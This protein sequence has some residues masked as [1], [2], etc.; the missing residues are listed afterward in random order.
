[1]CRLLSP[2]FQ[3]GVKKLFD[4]HFD[5]YEG[6]LLGACVVFLLIFIPS[7]PTLLRII[8]NLLTSPRSRL[9]RLESE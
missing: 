1:M 8:Y 4:D 3:F 6:V 9:K 7:L 5:V 2:R